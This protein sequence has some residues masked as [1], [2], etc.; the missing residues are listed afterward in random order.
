MAWAHRYER[1][2]LDTDHQAG[3]CAVMALGFPIGRRLLQLSGFGEQLGA[4]LTRRILLVFED[5]NE[6]R[7][8]VCVRLLVLRPLRY[9]VDDK[10]FHTT[11]HLPKPGCLA[12]VVYARITADQSD[13]TQW[14]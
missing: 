6:R 9:E 1:V 12:L 11:Y 8:C 14:E 13:P 3:A 7:F 5:D 10:K 4:R 2:A